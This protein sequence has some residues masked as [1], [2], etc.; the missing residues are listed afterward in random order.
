MLLHE[1]CVHILPLAD[2]MYSGYIS[3]FKNGD[4]FKWWNN[5]RKAEKE[6][7]YFSVEINEGMIEN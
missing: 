5:K 7:F 4:L 1:K 2:Q 3:Q 6:V